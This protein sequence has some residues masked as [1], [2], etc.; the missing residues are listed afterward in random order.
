MKK[1]LLMFFSPPIDI[2]SQIETK[3]AAQYLTIQRLLTF[4]LNEEKQSEWV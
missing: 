1:N 3:Y 2:S 4:S